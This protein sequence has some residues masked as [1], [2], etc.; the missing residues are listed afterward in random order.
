VDLRIQSVGLVSRLYKIDNRYASQSNPSNCATGSMLTA[1]EG[2]RE[3]EIKVTYDAERR[4]ASSL[5][6]DLKKNAIVGTREIDIP[7]CVHDVIGALF[8]L[9][10]LKVESGGSV[11]IPVSDGRKSV[12]ARVEAQEQA[13]IR[14]PAG[15]FQT[16]RYEAFLMNDV[17]YRRKGRL[18]VWLSNDERRLPVQVQVRLPFYVGTVT[19]QLEKVET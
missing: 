11:Q 6:R 19:L 1:L 18:F 2:S 17:L 13:T 12:L 10:K 15:S 3:R 14:T 9:R 16:T 7:S 5:E 4:K 8:Q